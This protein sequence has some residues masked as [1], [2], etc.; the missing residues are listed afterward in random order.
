[1]TYRVNGAAISNEI[2]HPLVQLEIRVID[3]DLY[4]IHHGQS[5]NKREDNHVGFSKLTDLGYKQAYSTGQVL[6][7]IN[8]IKLYC[9][10]ML[11]AVQTAQKIG[12]MI[13][14]DLQIIIELHEKG[15]IHALAPRKR[16]EGLKRAK[17]LRLCPMP[18]CRKLLQKRDGGFIKSTTKDTVLGMPSDRDHARFDQNNCGTSSIK[19]SSEMT[20]LVFLN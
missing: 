13:N 9:N 12:D 2:I 8:L 3:M 14:L 6:S 4:L 20:Q 18:F 10:P 11:R 19:I 5:T 17:I 15:G 7:N 1:M 16:I